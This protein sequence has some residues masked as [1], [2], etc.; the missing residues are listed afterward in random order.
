MEE[1]LSQQSGLPRKKRGM[2][3][4]ASNSSATKPIKKQFLGAES[5]YDNFKVSVILP[6]CRVWLFCSTFFSTNAPCQY[7][8]S[9]LAFSFL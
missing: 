1:D 5:E 4:F 7:S 9:Y 6:F 2:E 8:I 3:T